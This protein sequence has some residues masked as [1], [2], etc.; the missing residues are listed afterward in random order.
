MQLIIGPPSWGPSRALETPITH[1][2][3]TAGGGAG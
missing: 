3:T 1:P 2:V